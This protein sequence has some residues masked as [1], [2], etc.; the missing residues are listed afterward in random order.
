MLAVGDV[1]L[2]STGAGV[3]VGET[4]THW[5]TVSFAGQFEFGPLRM[6][7]LKK[8]GA[9]I[10][11]FPHNTHHKIVIP[12]MLD[13]YK[14]AMPH[15]QQK[16]AKAHAALLSF[17]GQTKGNTTMATK[18]SNERA[19]A[20]KKA[21]DSALKA[22]KAEEAKKVGA[23]KEVAAAKGKPVPAKTEKSAK[24]EKPA[25]VKIDDRREEDRRA[26]RTSAI[27]PEMK[28]KLLVTENP[29]RAGAA[30]RF[31]LYK[32]GMTVA[33]YLELGGTMADVRWDVKQKFVS[34]A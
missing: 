23:K 20:Y 21:G 26:G 15:L 3:I 10:I 12:A 6:D 9:K 13:A 30:T 33:K 8:V 24:T 28:V 2:T 4:K 14:S 27:K 1:I 5:R 34:V 25:K 19:D 31:A 11:L 32:D 16:S 22:A 18:M 17:M 7:E 29:K